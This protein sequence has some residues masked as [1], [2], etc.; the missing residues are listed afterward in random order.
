MTDGLPPI[1]AARPHLRA[2]T[3][4]R[5]VAAIWVV[6]Y[7]L[8]GPRCRDVVPLVTPIVSAGYAAVGLFFV[9]SGFI[10]TYT[11]GQGTE[12][13]E[14]LRRRDFFVARLAR[15]YPVYALGLVVSLPFFLEWATSASAFGP[16][17]TLR[18]GAA[19][20]TTLVLAQSWFAGLVDRWNGP[21]WSL[22]VEA[23]FYASFPLL[24]PVLA[25]RSTSQL[26]AIALTAWLVPL[27]GL[28]VLVALN[29]DGL[30]D[31]SPE[32]T[33]TLV[34]M[35]K[36]HPL[37]RLPEFV[38]GCVLGRLFVR[39]GLN[40]RA[41]PGWWATLAALAIVAITLV[42]PPLPYVL[43]HDALLVPP[44]AVIV[45]TL[46]GG[47]GDIAR[48]LATRSAVALGEAS[49]A[50]YILHTAISHWQDRLLPP[51][52]VHSMRGRLVYLV[53]AVVV[54]LV[55]FRIIEEPAR[56]A[57]RRRFAPP[58]GRLVAARLGG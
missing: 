8:C 30:R 52:F 4:L 56:R 10:L 13:G 48:V 25:R 51:D 57:I 24:L 45:W 26:R 39:S 38:V 33:G 28:L 22:S 49:Y 53:F 23:A 44:F 1:H 11:Y 9:L 14:R 3:G 16:E 21:G 20:A 27:V 5:F 42:N 12:R 50:L 41:A 40:A 47:R 6:G 29:V 17:G 55:V 35:L 32:S 18:A 15:V 43:L 37:M 19:A 46:A 7:H 2:L 34:T 31:A 36:F 54:S 58:G